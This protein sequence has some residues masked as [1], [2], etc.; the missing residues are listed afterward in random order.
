MKKKIHK[1]WGLGLVV[2]LAASLLLSAAPV[3]AG[4]LSWGDEDLPDEL[5]MG[6]ITDLAVFPGGSVIYAA[7]DMAG[8]DGKIFRSTN[9]GESWSSITVVDGSNVMTDPTF[10]AVAPDDEN[11]IAAANS[12]GG[13]FIS[14]DA[15]ANWDTLGDALTTGISGGTLNDL[16][17]SPEKA[18]RHTVAAACTDAAAEVWSYEIG[19]VGA[20]W[21][22]TSADTG[23]APEGGDVA[24]AVAF[25]PNFALWSWS[26][27]TTVSLS[28]Y[29]STASIKTTGTPA[30]FPTTRRKLLA[31]VQTPMSTNLNQ[32]QSPWRRT[33]WAVMMPCVSSSSV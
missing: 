25:S 28:I 7:H 8:A 30:H 15:G 21:T 27:P 13:V 23:F 12:T 29:I 22:E 33:T 24:G 20:D 31:M 1:I 6:S 17:M 5:E 18:G 19:G 4:T 3:S 2:V 26:L 11:Y 9:R 10:V 14:S 16:A 32:R